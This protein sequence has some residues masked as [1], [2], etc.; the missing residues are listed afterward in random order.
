M[1]AI[2]IGGPKHGDVELIGHAPS[3]LPAGEANGA[4]AIYK[5]GPTFARGAEGI[6]T[7]VWYI[8]DG[9]TLEE[10]QQQ[11]KTIKL[12]RIG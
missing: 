5:K 6:P 1:H 9:M 4:P 8:I 2:F 7:E 11:V 12:A 10:A 3:R